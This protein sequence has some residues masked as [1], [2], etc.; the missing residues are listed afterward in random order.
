MNEQER[1]ERPIILEKNGRTSSLIGGTQAVTLGLAV[2][3]NGPS[4]AAELSPLLA[5]DL[6]RH[7]HRKLHE[8]QLAE[9]RAHWVGGKIYNWALNVE[10]GY[11][12]LSGAHLRQTITLFDLEVPKTVSAQK[13]YLLRDDIARL[14]H[15]TL[16]EQ[17]GVAADTMAQGL[18]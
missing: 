6:L 8:V 18:A 10:L 4:R 2:V 5:E 15:D 1:H 12:S 13:H 7:L 3:V 16:G 9:Q 14:A 11:I 17:L